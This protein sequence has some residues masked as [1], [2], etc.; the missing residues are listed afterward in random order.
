[1]GMNKDLV[2]TSVDVAEPYTV[3]ADAVQAY[4]DATSA[5]DIA[6]YQQGDVPALFSVVYLLPGLTTV[7][8]NKDLGADLLRLVHG[9]QDMTFI[10]PT[11]VGDVLS[12]RAT[13]ASIE[14][15]A[16]GETLSAHIVARDEQGAPV[17]DSTS[18]IFVR[19]GRQKRGEKAPVTLPD[20]PDLFDAAVTVDDDQS[21]RYADASGDHNPIHKDDNV[22]QMAGLPRKILHG[23]CTMAFAHNAFVRHFDGRADCLSQFGVR[24][25][26][27]VLMGDTLRVQA[28]AAAPHA[29]MVRNQDGTPVITHGKA[30]PR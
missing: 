10:R 19:K 14:E 5:G 28:K 9:E 26:R 20:G 8:L 23:L 4:V 13:I 12:V 7:V 1:M 18:T 3:T 6:A 11:R 2:G 21:L 25:A 30:T 27:P 29:F 17:V 15:K 22:A 16:T 24:F